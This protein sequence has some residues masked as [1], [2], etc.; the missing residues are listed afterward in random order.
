M[1][2]INSLRGLTLDQYSS[3]PNSFEKNSFRQIYNTKE[4]QLLRTEFILFDDFT[5]N[6]YLRFLFDTIL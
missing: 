6:K 5:F 3:S 2:V 4:T 1:F